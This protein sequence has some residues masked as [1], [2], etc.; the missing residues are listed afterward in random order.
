MFF[1]GSYYGENCGFS[2]YDCDQNLYDTECLKSKYKDKLLSYLYAFD[3]LDKF[4]ESVSITWKK[5]SA[6]KRMALC[7]ALSRGGL[8]DIDNISKQHIIPEKTSLLSGKQFRY[9]DIRGTW[10]IKR[11][12]ERVDKLLKLP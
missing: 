8:L 6:T 10:D 2:S 12:S 4:P 7:K 11:I 9:K 5:M 1:I 3:N